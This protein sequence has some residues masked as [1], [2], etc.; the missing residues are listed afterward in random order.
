[1]DSPTFAAIFDQYK[2]KAYRLCLGYSGDADIA[3]DL[4]QE[5]FIKVWQH[6][7]EFRHEAALSTW[8]YRITVNTCLGHLRNAERSRTDR[9]KRHHE[10]IAEVPDERDAQLELLHQCI[11][12]LEEQDRIIISLVLESIPQKEIATITGISEGNVRVKIH[13]IKDKLTQLYSRHEEL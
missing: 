1:M 4:L 6:F 11:G 12:E 7:E 8:I 3:R 5:S 13:R 9:L 2:E 10:E